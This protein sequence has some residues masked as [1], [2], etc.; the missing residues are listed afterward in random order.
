MTQPVWPV[1]PRVVGGQVRVARVAEDRLDKIE[2]AHQRPG[3]EEPHLHRLLVAHAGHARLHQRPEHQRHPAPPITFDP[4]NKRQPHQVIGRP[5]R[6][7]DHVREHVLGHLALARG[8]GQAAL[9]NVERARRGP[10]VVTGVVQHAVEHAR[11]LDVGVLEGVALGGQRELARDAVAVQAERLPRQPDRVRLGDVRQ[12]APQPGLDPLIDRAAVL[13]GQP[14]LLVHRVALGPGK[15]RDLLIRAGPRLDQPL[16][17][18]PEPDQPVQILGVRS[19][20]TRI[21]RD[22]QRIHFNLQNI[23]RLARGGTDEAVL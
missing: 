7:L 21:Q 22:P 4:I 18:Q 20:G 1:Q 16:H 2:V 11:R 5:H 10:P 6:G 3:H 15:I 12:V 17:D 19:G 23:L 14:P 13:A 8:D 9:G